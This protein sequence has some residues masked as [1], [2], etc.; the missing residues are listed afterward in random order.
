[1]IKLFWDEK[2]GGFFFTATDAEKLLIRE[3][4]IYDGAIPSGNSI[5]ALDLLRMGR[6]TLNR[7]WEKKAQEYFKS[8]GQELSSGPSAYA[9]SV[10]ALDFAIGPSREIVLAGQKDDP[11]TQE[12]LKNLYNR[13]I[14][15]KVV[16]FRPSS[17]EEAKDIIDLIPFV[18]GQRA[19]DGKTTAYVC[20][21]YN[22]EFPTNE[23]E[24]F[25]QL[26]DQ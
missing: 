23:I 18:K 15:N 20:K 2:E 12:M 14:P 26:L 17:D 22:C 6:L 3:K 16:I 10:S 1:M 11:Q 24:K 7:E 25:E 8:F 9:Q 13:F 19:L 5:A 4:E 21:N